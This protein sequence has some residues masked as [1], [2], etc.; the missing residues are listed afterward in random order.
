MSCI[1]YKQKEC[2][3]GIHRSQK[4]ILNRN[5]KPMNF[6]V[7]STLRV[8]RAHLSSPVDKPLLLA[9]SQLSSCATLRPK[10]LR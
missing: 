2:L 4:M 7:E 9:Y 6:C 3:T 10:C 1:Y 5:G 8:Y